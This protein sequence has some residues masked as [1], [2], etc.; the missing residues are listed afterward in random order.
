[1]EKLITVMAILVL[2]ALGMVTTEAMT[3][4]TSSNI[5]IILSK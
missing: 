5:N 1:M 2:M 4:D 3:I